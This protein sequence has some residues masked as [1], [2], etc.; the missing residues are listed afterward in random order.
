ML[1]HGTHELRRRFMPLSGQ[2]QQEVHNANTKKYGSSGMDHALF[3][4]LLLKFNENAK[5]A[6]THEIDDERTRMRW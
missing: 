4:N 2:L 6:N 3:L 1:Y 5:N